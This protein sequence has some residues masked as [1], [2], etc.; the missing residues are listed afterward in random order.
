MGQQLSSRNFAAAFVLAGSA[1]LAACQS[2]NPLG[3]LGSGRTAEPP[4]G[5]IRESE[6][7]AYCPPVL[8]S[9]ETAVLTT[10]EG[11]AQGDPE[12]IVHRASLGKTSRACT[13]GQGTG[14][15]NAAIAGRVIPGPRGRTGTI[16]LPIRIEARRG[17]EVLYSQLFRHTVTIADTAGA[18]Q[19]LLSDPNIVIPGGIDRS[20]RLTA[21]FEQGR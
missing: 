15:I 13:F 19:F 18:T 9:D 3:A 16:T 14:T 8:L 21:G 2:G 12:R 11:N 4:E 1:F 17:D 6:L 7:R 20:V 5:A 10:Y